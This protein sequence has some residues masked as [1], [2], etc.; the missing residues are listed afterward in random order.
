MTE[1]RI[2]GEV[3]GNEPGSPPL[4]G[5]HGVPAQQLR[6]R[7]RRGEV[8]D[9][10]AGGDLWRLGEADE[11]LGRR[12]AVDLALD[13]VG[14]PDQSLLVASVS[15]R[16]AAEV[17]LGRP[18]QTGRGCQAHHPGAQGR[19]GGHGRGDLPED[20][21]QPSDRVHQS[22]H[23]LGE[24]VRRRL[25]R[26]TEVDRS[27][28]QQAGVNLLSTQHAMR[29]IGR[30]GATNA[31]EHGDQAEQRPVAVGQDQIAQRGARR[32]ARD[33][34]AGFDLVAILRVGQVRRRGGQSVGER[35]EIGLVEV[36]DLLQVVPAADG[37][38]PARE[39]P[40]RRL[41]VVALL[42]SEGARRPLQGS[43]AAS[44]AGGDHSNSHQSEWEICELA[45]S[46]SGAPGRR[47]QPIVTSKAGPSRWSP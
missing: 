24:V 37:A 14:R 11:Q 30:P 43:R 10:D 13:V 38:S 19:G 46:S 4:G 32:A 36:L 3:R 34:D 20:V 39:G 40:C 27:L 41:F 22:E 35:G 26:E 28:A 33:A 18:H 31:A 16:G 29:L 23:R 9:R 25:L 5:E 45:M 12:G 7:I 6:D 1:A 8:H 44:A 21:G 2:G 17:R 42:P 15:F 47:C